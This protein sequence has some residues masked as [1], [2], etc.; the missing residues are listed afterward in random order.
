MPVVMMM[1]IGEPAHSMRGG[2]AKCCGAMR[3][4]G[5]EGDEGR[6]ERGEG[7]GM[8]KGSGLGSGMQRNELEKE[9]V[10]LFSVSRRQSSRC[11]HQ[12]DRKVPYSHG[13]GLMDRQR[14]NL[15]NHMAEG[16]N[17]K[18]TRRIGIQSSCHSSA[19]VMV[20]SE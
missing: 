9:R 8:G 18:R 20:L 5:G 10:P 16:R 17:K 14:D 13:R 7:K 4:V 3:W 6:L 1:L 11:S 2:T 12:P 15:P 19:G